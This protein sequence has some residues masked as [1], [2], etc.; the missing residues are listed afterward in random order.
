MYKASAALVTQNETCVK[1]DVA[2]LS[3]YDGSD[4]T[5]CDTG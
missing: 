1:P 4:F 5:K 3:W 2:T